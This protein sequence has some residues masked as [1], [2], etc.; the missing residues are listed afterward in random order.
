MLCSAFI[1]WSLDR[2]VKRQ[3]ER[4]AG[5]FDASTLAALDQERHTHQA[6][7]H[8]CHG[9]RFRNSRELHFGSE[10]LADLVHE[11]VPGD[12][13]EAV[14][15]GVDVRA[16]GFAV[17]VDLLAAHEEQHACIVEAAVVLVVEVEAGAR[18]QAQGR[19][20]G[21]RTEQAH[22]VAEVAGDGRDVV[23]SVGREAAGGHG[24]LAGVEAE[25]A[26]VVRGAGDGGRAGQGSGAGED[27][28]ARCGTQR[29]VHVYLSVRVKG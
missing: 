14:G 1:I 23:G 6:G 21:D 7:E 24:A 10:G 27:R 22:R 5:G 11:Q 19:Q 12:V 18:A 26:E 3:L 29:F 17:Q 13:T 25:E 9:S 15:V 20:A 4:S 28:Q 2:L 16:I 8:Q